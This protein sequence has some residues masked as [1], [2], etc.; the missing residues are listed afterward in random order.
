MAELVD[1]LAG[2]SQDENKKQ[3]D[4]NDR[5]K[6]KTE[7]EPG[8]KLVHGESVVKIAERVNRLRRVEENFERPSQNY[9]G[10]DE[11]IIP[12]HAPPDRFEPTDFE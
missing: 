8:G 2:G 6:V 1:L 4:G 9:D 12:L 10:E 7:R 5:S 3:R 11:N